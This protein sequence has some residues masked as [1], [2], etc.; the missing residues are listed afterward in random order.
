MTAA[1]DWRVFCA[2]SLMLDFQ[3]GKY[4]HDIRLGEV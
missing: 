3:Q 4:E 2:Y 1:V